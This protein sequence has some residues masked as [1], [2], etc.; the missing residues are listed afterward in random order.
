MDVMNTLSLII[1]CLAPACQDGWRD[2]HRVHL[3]NGNFVDGRLE[4]VG[5]K[6]ILLRWSP[7]ALMRIKIMD[8]RG[9]GIEEIKIRT[10]HSPVT[11]V[12]IRETPPPVGDTPIPPVE[13]PTRDGAAR[14]Q[15]EIDKLFTRLMSQPDMTYDLLVKEVRALGPVGARSMIA[16]LPSMDAQKTNLVLMALDQ[17]RDL[18]IE[19]EI[20]GLLES[21]RADLR[22]AA[23]NLLSNRVATGSLKSILALFRDPTPQVRAAALMAVPVFGDATTLEPVANLAVDPDASVRS[24]AF[25]SAED[26]SSRVAGDNDLA[27][28]WLSLAGRGPSGAL[29]DFASSLGRLAERANDAFPAGEVR[30]RLTDMLTDRD[31]AARGAAAYALSAVRPA[32]PSAHAILSVFDSEGEPKVLVSMCDSLGRLKILKC[33]EPLIEK[34]RADS[35]EVKAAAQRGLEKITGNTENGSDPDK[36]KEW[37][38]KSKGQ[39]P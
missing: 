18:P 2:T 7:T 9:D 21:K 10:L 4:G 8:I 27:Q 26:L 13:V 29:A 37:F 16:E 34:L 38:D 31:P 22:A 30:V 12:P 32:D 25:R 20:R 14:P 35:R 19:A 39:N 23:C 17:M 24:R 6:E 33:I 3:R 1:L 15:S 5:D 11:K 36:W 28:R